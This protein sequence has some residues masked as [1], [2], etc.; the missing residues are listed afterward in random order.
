MSDSLD[1]LLY[2]HMLMQRH[3]V[4]S[5]GPYGRQAHLDRS[6]TLLLA[7]L[8]AEGPMTVAQLSE[9]FGLD[10]STVHR[11][12]AAAIKHGLIEKV[13]DPDGGAAWLHQASDEGKARL[14]EEFGARHET[15]ADITSDWNDDDVRTFAELMRRFNEQVEERRGQPWP[16]KNDDGA[17]GLLE[18][19]SEHDKDSARAT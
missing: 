3:V 15:F 11:Q 9:A 16:R 18:V 19:L 17:S 5:T 12:L 4:H 7:R 10:I 13:R 2:E 6:A 1:S 14:E 8:K